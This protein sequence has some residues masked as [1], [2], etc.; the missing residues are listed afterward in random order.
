MTSFFYALYSDD[1]YRD[2]IFN[3]DPEETLPWDQTYY[4]ILRNMFG[5]SFAPDFSGFKLI[6]NP[7]GKKRKRGADIFIVSASS[8]M[9]ISNKALDILDRHLK[10]STQ[11]IKILPPMNG[12]QALHVTKVIAD[13]VDWDK[14]DYR[15]SPNGRVLYTP[16]LKESKVQGEDIF[17]LHE[18]VT[19]IFFSDN[20]KKKCESADL[21]GVNFSLHPPI[22]AT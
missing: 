1:S 19:R 18:D 20:L 11:L 9:V 6:E 2:L 8:I 4:A 7:D 17:M 3:D 5:K 21:K 13:A 12:Y 22:V 16:S 10:N 15:N 14:S